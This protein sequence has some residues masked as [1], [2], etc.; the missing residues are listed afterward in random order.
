MVG[1]MQKQKQK[2]QQKQKQKQQQRAFG[3]GL[4]VHAG[5]EAASASP[6]EVDAAVARGDLHLCD[7][8][9][10][11]RAPTKAKKRKHKNG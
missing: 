5:V 9:A 8:G 10:G 4:P 1:A 3:G 7:S 11:T 6:E 2:L